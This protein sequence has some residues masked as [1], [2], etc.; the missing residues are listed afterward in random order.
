M[1]KMLRKNGVLQGSLIAQKMRKSAGRAGDY[2][3][4]EYLM[5]MFPK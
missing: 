2:E 1:Q 4:I 3:Q 5:T